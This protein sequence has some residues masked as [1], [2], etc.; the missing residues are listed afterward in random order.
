MNRDGNCLASP[1][2]CQ[3]KRVSSHGWVVLKLAPEER[4][5]RFTTRHPKFCKS[6]TVVFPHMREQLMRQQKR[7]WSVATFQ[8]YLSGEQRWQRTFSFR[9]GATSLC[10]YCCCATLK[11]PSQP[12]IASLKVTWSHPL[13]TISSHASFAV[14][15]TSCTDALPQ[16][17]CS[18]K[19]D[20][21]W[22]EDSVLFSRSCWASLCWMPPDLFLFVPFAVEELRHGS[23]LQ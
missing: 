5:I 19:K 20:A 10:A 9:N 18:T 8:R 3:K 1:I 2:F 15:C 6:F 16:T 12:R 14:S 11:F 17:H 22:L 23:K 7:L 4:N 21:S 13:F